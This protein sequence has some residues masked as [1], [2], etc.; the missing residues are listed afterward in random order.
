MG[1]DLHRL[2][3]ERSLALHRLVVERARTDPQVLRKA[4]QRVSEWLVTGATA[5]FYAE[6]WAELL[7]RPDEA[8]FA[9]LVDGSEAARALRQT[10]PFA[11]VIDPRTRWRL[12]REV[13][14][15]LEAA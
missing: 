1:L 7:R 9:A 14:S 13:R 5:R 8:I 15:R 2:A 6:A 3:E 4:R 11:G 10:T 12:W